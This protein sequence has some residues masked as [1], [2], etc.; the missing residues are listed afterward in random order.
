MAYLKRVIPAQRR[1]WTVKD[2]C[3]ETSLSRATAYRLMSAGELR[4]VMIGKARRIT[5]SP[6]DFIRALEDA[7]AA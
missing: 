6:T 4:F 5:T 3:A 7:S 1:A 2:W